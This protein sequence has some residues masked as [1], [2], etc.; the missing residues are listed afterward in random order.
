[1]DIKV[2]DV[3]TSRRRT[4]VGLSVFLLI[5]L[6]ATVSGLE[7]FSSKNGSAQVPRVSSSSRTDNKNDSEN[8][9]QA[10]QPLQA[11]IPNIGTS[12]PVKNLGRSL[13]LM[14]N[15]V[16]S[17]DLSDDQSEEWSNDTYLDNDSIDQSQN[18]PA[19]T[20]SSDAINSSSTSPDSSESSSANTQ[21]NNSVQSEDTTDQDDQQ[22]I[23]NDQSTDTSRTDSIMQAIIDFW[24]RLWDLIWPATRNLWSNIKSLLSI[25]VENP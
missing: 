14:L 18:Q 2:S 10:N 3:R 20:T 13:S 5:L 15:K 24:W 8:I 11:T 25:R 6:V 17:S 16:I 7:V 22:L 1:M 19:T 9:K 23:I 4:V 12:T 21:T